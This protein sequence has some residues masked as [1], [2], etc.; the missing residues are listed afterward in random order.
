[1]RL[2]VVVEEPETFALKLRIP[3]WSS[4]NE[5]RVN[6]SSESAPSPG[7]YHAIDRTWEAGDIV[8]LSLDLSGHFWAG[9]RELAG[10]TSLYRGPIVL[11]Y[12][13]QYNDVEPGSVPLI[14]APDAVRDLGE[15]L[16][17]TGWI[18]PWMLFRCQ[19]RDGSDVFLCDYASAGETGTPYRTWL[20][21]EGVSPAA[22]TR[23]DPMRI[24][25]A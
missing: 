22:F 18:Q 16:S 5:V 2:T 15:P 10:Q 17:H 21:I 4:E 25:R 24:V 1:M 20:P 9:E 11:T 7:A 6:G 23:E 19:A 13:W 12:D 14:D 8:D 3:Q